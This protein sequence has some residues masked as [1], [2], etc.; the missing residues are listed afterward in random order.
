[1]R[2]IIGFVLLVS[3]TLSV[4]CSTREE[5]QARRAAEAAALEQSFIRTCLNYGFEEGNA[6]FNQCLASEERSYRQDQEI[7]QAKKQA[8]RAEFEASQAAAK[9]RQKN[10]TYNSPSSSTS[11]NNYYKGCRRSATGTV[12]GVCY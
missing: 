9:A 8:R 4:S 6:Q 2:R 7:E 5:R 11:N 1:M 12:V 3:L 10:N